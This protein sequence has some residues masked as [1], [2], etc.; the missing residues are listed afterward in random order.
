MNSFLF[1]NCDVFNMVRT[2]AG[3]LLT[4]FVIIPLILLI[5][6]G[7]LALT[8]NGIYN[9]CTS[10]DLF[11]NTLKYMADKS[12]SFWS[13]ILSGFKTK[14][15]TSSTTSATT[16]T[17][18]AQG[19]ECTCSFINCRNVSC[20]GDVCSVSQCEKITCSCR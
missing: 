14:Q 20:E 11:C 18:V 1:Q 15:T 16:Q 17:N 12:Y 2:V 13:S 3:V 5:S 6:S 19:K 9:V 8:R 7:F 4:L 10:N